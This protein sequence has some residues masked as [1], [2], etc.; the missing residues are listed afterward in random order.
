[1]NQNLRYIHKLYTLVKR[2][3]AVTPSREHIK[4]RISW[5]I[6]RPATTGNRARNSLRS[7]P[8]QISLLSLAGKKTL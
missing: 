6:R 4:S 3:R 5:K 7:A 1:M 2:R 8:I